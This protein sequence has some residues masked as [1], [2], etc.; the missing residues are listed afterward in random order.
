MDH[1]DN[2]RESSLPGLHGLLFPISSKGH[3]Y[4][5]HPQQDKTYQYLCYTSRAVL[6]GTRNNLIG[7]AR[8]IDPTIYNRVTSHSLSYLSRPTL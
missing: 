2:E 1:S 7:S 4:M 3:V 8:G 5:I 6:A